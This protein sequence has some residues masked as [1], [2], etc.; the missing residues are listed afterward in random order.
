MLSLLCVS[1]S[2]HIGRKYLNNCD[3]YDT[4]D[5]VIHLLLLLELGS[6]VGVPHHSYMYSARLRN[7]FEVVN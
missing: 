5:A 4:E 3:H 7:E 1:T 2:C 6:G